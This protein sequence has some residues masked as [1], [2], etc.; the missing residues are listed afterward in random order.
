[1][2]EKDYRKKL[3]P[4]Q[5]RVIRQGGKEAAHTGKYWDFFESGTYRCAACGATL[6]SS[7][8]KFNSGTGYPS[9]RKPLNEKDLE[10][11]PETAGKRAEIRCSTCKSHLGYVVA[12]TDKI[13]YR[14]NS[15]G[16]NFQ[17][18]KKIRLAELKDALGDVK[19]AQEELREQFDPERQQGESAGQQSP[20]LQSIA[21]IIAGAII[22]GA[23]IAGV[24]LS[25]A[26]PFLCPAPTPA[27]VTPIATST[28][29]TTTIGASPRAT[30]TPA[31]STT[32]LGAPP[33]ALPSSSPAATSSAGTP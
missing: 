21:L 31:R 12:D 11:K 17:P 6:F 14:L 22:G 7:K 2:D 10:Y 18:E 20:T 26:A 32:P 23:G 4:E 8:E 1:M 28:A 30:T 9:F 33:S 3:T 13:Y 15:I 24:S 19:D 5:F 29:A 16:L 27:A 25:G